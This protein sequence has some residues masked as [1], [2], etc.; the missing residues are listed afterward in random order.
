MR[1]EILPVGKVP[2]EVLRKVILTHIGARRPE[3]ILG[4]SEGEDGAVLRVG[5]KI[6]VS[7]VDPISGALE[8]VGWEAVNI[9]ANDVA[10][11]GVKPIFFSSCILLPKKASVEVVESIC[12]EID[13][14][15]KA[16]DM[17]VIG[18][19]SEIT[20][21]L[22]HPIVVGFSMGITE[23]G[24]YVTSAG[25]RPGDLILITK[26]VGLEGAS[27]L[28]A[29]RYNLLRGVM[30]E[31]SLRIAKEFYRQISVVKEALLAFD[32]GGVTAMHDPTE[33]GLANGIHELSDASNVGFKVYEEKIPVASETREICNFFGIDPLQLISSGVLLAT[34]RPEFEKR[35]T[36]L[37][38]KNGVETSIIG[39]VLASKE[40]RIIVR[41][42]GT[43]AKLIRPLS[44]H[45]WKALAK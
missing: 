11:F 14:A 20:P 5:D 45:L 7:S 17:A 15:A 2:V 4:P 22:D 10:T 12:G 40:K 30:S 44:D 37:L 39:E 35:I 16:L 29:D 34:I 38:E 42:D 25:A 21:G 32:T 27:I 43:E 36:T 13:S 41:K 26:H 33:G 18:G 6:I 8:K 1:R 31:D 24:E 3:V 9:S 23:P 28:A 19:H